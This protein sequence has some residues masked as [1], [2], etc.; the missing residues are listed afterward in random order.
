MKT[1][2]VELGERRYPIYV[3]KGLLALLPDYLKKLA[4]N[5]SFYIIT[6]ENV[7]QL[8][9]ESVLASM[10]DAGLHAALFFVPAGEGSKSLEYAHFLYTRLLENQATR[11]SV[12]IAL[13]G[14]VVGDLA[15]FVAATFMRGIAL[16]QIPTS[17][18][19]QVDSSVGG[20]V[21]INHPLGKNLIGAFYQPKF[22]LID[23]EVLA[24]LPERE[25]RAG[26]AEIIKYGYIYDRE[27]YNLISNNLDSLLSLK[28]AA[29]LERAL[30]RSCEIKAAVVAQDETES[31][32]RAILNFGH[33]IGHAIEA[34]TSYTAF[35]HGEAVV[36]GMKAA[37]YLS[38]L[39][40][41][42]TSA[43]VD[44]YISVLHQFKTPKFPA[45]VTYETLQHTMQ[46]DKKRSAKGQQWVLLQEIGTA[47]L[48]RS[49]GEEWVK[50]AVAYMIQQS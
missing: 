48:T 15:G 32:L 49:V 12:V 44:E 1:V 8:Y 24:T 45:N 34:A 28:D 25:I 39:A 35:L 33:T 40:G 37:L 30:C 9:G 17:V 41:R 10:R 13:G 36:H 42:F 38:H 22:V 46:N 27:F 23:P 3:E 6:D 14:G 43:Q 2:F 31:G 7:R 5:E 50:K 26:A 20:K 18:L 4:A 21:G 16:V 11:Q 29:L 19:A 47:F